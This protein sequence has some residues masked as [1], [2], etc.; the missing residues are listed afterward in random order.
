M[1]FNPSCFTD[2]T[3]PDTYGNSGIN[4]LY[5]DGQQQLDSSLSKTFD[6]TERV[7]LQLRVDVFNT[8]NHTN[9]GAPD[10]GVGDGS[11]GVVTSTSVDNRRMQFGLRLHF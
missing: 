11:E 10:S 6:V 5:A 1:W 9:F 7:N 3:V 8:F 2:D 4:P